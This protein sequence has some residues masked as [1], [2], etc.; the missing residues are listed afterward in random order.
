MEKLREKKAARKEVEKDTKVR[1]DGEVK[2]LGAAIQRN[3]DYNIMK[4]KGIT[5]KRPKKDKNP[6]TKKRA[7][8]EKMLKTHKNAVQEFQAGKK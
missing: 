5:R 1:V 7:K 2:R 6:R 4:A 8:Y 3:V